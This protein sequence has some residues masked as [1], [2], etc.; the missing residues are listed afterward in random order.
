MGVCQSGHVGLAS[1]PDA[2]FL[3]LLTVDGIDQVVVVLQ[4]AFVFSLDVGY[5]SCGA[6]GG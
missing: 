1:L 2:S 3:A 4:V 5:S 6:S